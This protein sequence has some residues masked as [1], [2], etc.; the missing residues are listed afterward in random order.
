LP[1]DQK[2]KVSVLA[3]LVVFKKKDFSAKE[4]IKKKV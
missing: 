3:N 4:I 2:N 1:I